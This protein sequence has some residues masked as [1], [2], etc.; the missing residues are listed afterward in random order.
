[1][2]AK[3]HASDIATW[4]GCR[5]K[6]DW[7]SV[8]RR[9]LEPSRPYTPF[10]F[11]RA[12][13]HALEHFY[14][15]E[16]SPEVS[17]GEFWRSEIA[18]M[19][20][21][22]ALWPEEENLIAEQWDFSI[23]LM[24]HYV[25]WVDELKGPLANEHF[26]T[27]DM[28]VRFDVPLRNSLGVTSD[29]ARLGGRIDGVVRRKSDGTLWLREFKTARS[30]KERINM[31]PFDEQPI[32]YMI[33]AAEHYGE[34]IHGVIYDILKKSEPVVPKVLA[35][36]FLSQAK[37]IKTSYRV[38]L[39]TI[40]RHHGAEATSEFIK[41][42]YGQILVDLRERDTED[43]FFQRIVVQRNPVQ[44]EMALRDIWVVAHEMVDPTMNVYPSPSYGCSFCQFK[45]PCALKNQGLD[46]EYELSINYRS[47]SDNP[48]E[49]IEEEGE[50]ETN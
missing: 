14:R 32:L 45:S 28:E 27:V 38:Y 43:P 5:R 3:I 35:N 15:S 29:V 31:L 48:E 34:P 1:M 46:Y 40:R 23:R 10:I 21:H 49:A 25:M 8:L 13:H 18:R 9:N 44:M 24:N 4:K 26:E 42:N 37:S 6:W 12:V 47:R 20:E 17:L 19:S 41:S 36:G 7:S 22:G 16:T 50:H 11:G 39:D 2:Q 30:I 33:A